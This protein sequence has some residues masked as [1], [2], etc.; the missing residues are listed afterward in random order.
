VDNEE[1]VAMSTTDLEKL[2]RDK[3]LHGVPEDPIHWFASVTACPTSG[4]T[5]DRGAR[6][7]CGRC[8]R[9]F[10]VVDGRVPYHQ[11]FPV[12]AS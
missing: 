2:N 10:D 9:T 5:V 6:V 1:D 7:T 8:R 3:L 11:I 4:V 12:E